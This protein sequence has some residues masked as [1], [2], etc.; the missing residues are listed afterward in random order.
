VNGWEA[1]STFHKPNATT[2]APYEK[3]LPY[4]TAMVTKGI[5]WAPTPD[6][7]ALIELRR[8]TS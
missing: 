8:L 4:T 1:W 2:P 7:S 6:P 5:I 3:H